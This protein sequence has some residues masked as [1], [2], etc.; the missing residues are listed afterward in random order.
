M[1]TKNIVSAIRTVQTPI[2]KRSSDGG[3]LKLGVTPAGGAAAG[4]WESGTPGGSSL[5]IIA[6]RW[7][8]SGS[9]FKWLSLHAESFPEVGG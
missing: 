1:V 7:T 8:V 6:E 5:D 9:S 2:T 4:I 3:L